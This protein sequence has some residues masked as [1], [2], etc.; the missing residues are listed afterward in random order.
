MQYEKKDD[1]LKGFIK[2]RLFHTLQT[3]I[4]DSTEY[5]N[6]LAYYKTCLLQGWVANISNALPPPWAVIPH[7]HYPGPLPSPTGLQLENDNSFFICHY[8][9]KFSLYALL[10]GQSVEP[11][12]HKSFCPSR[13]W[14]DPYLLVIYWVISITVAG[15]LI[16]TSP[17][18]HASRDAG[19]CWQVECGEAD[20]SASLG[21][22]GKLAGGWI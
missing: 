5:Y 11:Q 16:A 7:L 10:S 9:N 18:S 1:F 17:P 2:L 4:Q 6:N 22:A 13:D 15:L 12:I 21:E 19:V 8:S 20:D 3:Y 14:Y